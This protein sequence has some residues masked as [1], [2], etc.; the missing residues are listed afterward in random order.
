[1]F[2]L[3]GESRI[4]H[5]GRGPP[6]RALYGE[7]VCENKRIGSR[8]GVVSSI[9]HHHIEHFFTFLAGNTVFSLISESPR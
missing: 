2:W 6:T 7:N 4:S 3:S 9:Y 1:M 8:R 5:G